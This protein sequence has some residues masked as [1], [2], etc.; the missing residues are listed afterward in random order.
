MNEM[1]DH[2]EKRETRE[3]NEWDDLCLRKK[4]LKMEEKM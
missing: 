4:R 1:K 2:N 3:M